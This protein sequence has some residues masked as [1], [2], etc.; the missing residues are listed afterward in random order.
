MKEE[1]LKLMLQNYSQF[2]IAK[3]MGLTVDEVIKYQTELVNGTKHK[4]PIES[5]LNNIKVMEARAFE[6][7]DNYHAGLGNELKH[8]ITNLENARV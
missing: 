4:L 2:G 3:I 7:A 1:V 5:T 6:I 8:L